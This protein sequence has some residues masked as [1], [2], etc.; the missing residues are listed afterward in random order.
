MWRAGR[1]DPAQVR[2]LKEA[3]ERYDLRPLVIHDNYLINLAAD[4]AAIRAL[5]I[6][7]FRGEVERALAIGAEFLVAHP[8]SYGAQGLERGLCRVI[9]SI[10]AALRGLKVK[11]LTILIEN[12]AGGG[13]RLGG[14]FEEL[15]ALGS[16]ADRF[17]DAE[18]G[19][20]L[21]TCH[22]LA[23]GYDLATAEGLAASL[24][25]ASTVL[26]LGRVKVI[27]A[28]D[29]KCGLGEHIDRH[30]H[31]G[32]GRIG[33][34]GFRRI[35]NH[36]KLRSK[37]FILETPRDRE[38]DDRRNVEMLKSLCRKRSTTTKRSS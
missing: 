27:H 18:V 26:G 7:A 28:N 14:S 36:P 29:S 33:A 22:C 17:L 8:G 38:G 30:E 12:T 5:S 23:S 34:E 32:G 3:R 4:D 10:D 15:H 20:C 19:Y 11:G 35:L 1:P 24:E 16:L 21:D 25:Q 13:T 31:I 2:K 9:E 6:A 37:P